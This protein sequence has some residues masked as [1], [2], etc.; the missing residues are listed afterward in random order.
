[1]PDPEPTVLV[2]DDDQ[3]IRQA[4]SD[5]LA[6]AG[7]R[8]LEASDGPAALSVVEAQRPDLV[9]VDMTMPG[10]MDGA[11]VARALHQRFAGSSMPVVV[12]S[13]GSDPRDRERARSAGCSA[14]LTKPCAP[15]RIREVARAMLAG[16]K[17]DSDL[18][19]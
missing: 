13:G 15:A 8:V 19:S 1:M 16:R 18:G 11:D 10:G 2:V 7:C 4:M 17:G 6:R 14:Y 3:G 9:F 5:V 12:L